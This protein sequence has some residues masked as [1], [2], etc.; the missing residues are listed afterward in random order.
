MCVRTKLLPEAITHAVSLSI[1][2]QIDLHLKGGFNT[3]FV[4]CSGLHAQQVSHEN[5]FSTG[6]VFY[7]DCLHTGRVLIH[8]Y[9]L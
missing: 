8:G 1:F 3:G 4:S 2:V 9:S 5:V 6:L 7:E